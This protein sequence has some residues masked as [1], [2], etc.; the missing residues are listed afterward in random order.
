[1]GKPDSVPPVQVK[2]FLAG[3]D[4]DQGNALTDE[5]RSQSEVKRIP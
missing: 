1:M 3:P 2:Q 5:V 4:A